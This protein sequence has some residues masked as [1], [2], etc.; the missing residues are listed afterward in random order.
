MPKHSHK[1]SS[2]HKSASRR[3]A[4]ATGS[5]KSSATS[6]ASRTGISSLHSRRRRSG[7][8]TLGW[9]LLLAAIIIVAVIY[10]ATRQPDRQG[11][12]T[13]LEISAA[14]AYEKYQAGAFFLDVREQSEWDAGYI[15]NTTHIPLG[16][17]ESRLSELPQDQEIVVVCRSGNRSQEGRDLLLENGFSNVSSVAGG[18]RDWGNAGYP[19]E[20]AIP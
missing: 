14:Q 19:F 7:V 16:E 5:V 15:P 8:G 4:P 6:S 20:G 10:F 13:A 1:S 11:T 9:V 12:A 18:V 3:S 17:L 2:M